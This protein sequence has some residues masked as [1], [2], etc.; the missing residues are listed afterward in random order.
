LGKSGDL[1]ILTL[2]GTGWRG[3][4]SLQWVQVQILGPPLEV[5][6]AGPQG[7]FAGL[8]QINVRL[9]SEPVARVVQELRLWVDGQPA[10]PVVISLEQKP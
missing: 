3:R 4:S 10:N 2:F 7:E 6:Y 9:P 1:V 5:L 8:D